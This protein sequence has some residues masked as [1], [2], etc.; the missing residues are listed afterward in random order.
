M[1]QIAAQVTESVARIS[2]GFL[3]ISTL[4]IGLNA[5]ITLILAL[6][7]VRARLQTQ[8]AIGDGGK[9][10]M[11]KATRA[12][13]NNVEYVPITL[14]TLIAIEMAGAEAWFVHAL[15]AGLTVARIAHAA[16]ISISTGRTIGRFGGTL[17]GWIVLLIGSLTC[18]YYGVN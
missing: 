5:L 4:Y 1:E 11:V 16:G 12:H 17:L 2:N 7:V 18:I 9:E 6:L 13:G 14:L 3:P 8:T 15:G 10:E